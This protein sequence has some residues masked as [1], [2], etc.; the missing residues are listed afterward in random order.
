M[1]TVIHSKLGHVV[2]LHGLFHRGAAMAVLSQRLQNKGFTTSVFSYPSRHREL[3]A[4]ANALR[5]FIETQKLTG[6]G[7]LHFIGHSLGGL[8]IMTLLD[9]YSRDLPSG[10]VVLLGSPVRGSSKARKFSSKKIG[11]A[12][13]GPAR[14]GLKA[15]SAVKAN[16]DVGV[17]AGIGSKG[18]GRLLG[19]MPDPNDGTVSVPET[20]VEG[21]MD[22]LLLPVSHFGLLLSPRVARECTSFL[23]SGCF[24]SSIPNAG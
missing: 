10:R 12:L 20:H 19:A 3:A 22:S 17:I 8:V 2:L 4:Q 11:R 24:D 23:K 5:E 14:H 15:G 13:L 16:R 18:V 9:K 6:P 7:P 1:T 21:A